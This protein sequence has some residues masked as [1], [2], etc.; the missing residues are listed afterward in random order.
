MMTR[1]ILVSTPHGVLFE[2]G[3]LSRQMELSAQWHVITRQ[4]VVGVESRNHRGE[5]VRIELREAES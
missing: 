1:P 4:G 2:I 5:P 3:R